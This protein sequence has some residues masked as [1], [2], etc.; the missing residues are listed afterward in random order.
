MFPLG[1]F[2]AVFRAAFVARHA[3]VVPVL[4]ADDFWTQHGQLARDNALRHYSQFVGCA[5]RHVQDP[6]GYERAAIIHPDHNAPIAGS[7]LNSRVERQGPVC[8][9]HVGLTKRFAVGRYA[10]PFVERTQAGPVCV[11]EKIARHDII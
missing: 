6:A 10:T 11:Y 5:F 1:S 7:H 8:R 3:S 9:R 2:V 4:F